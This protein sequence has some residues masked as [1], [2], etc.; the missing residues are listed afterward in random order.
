MLDAMSTL[1]TMPNEKRVRTMR[2]TFWY[3]LAAALLVGTLFKKIGNSAGVQFSEAALAII[4]II[5]LSLDMY[6]S[7]G[8]RCPECRGSTRE[9][10]DHP[11]AEDYHVLYCDECDILWD[12]TIPKSKD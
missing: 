12:T 6:F 3:L 5:G 2:Y 7:T 8:Q 10:Y 9:V 1:K 4:I 11:R